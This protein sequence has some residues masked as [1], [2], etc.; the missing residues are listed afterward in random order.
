MAERGPSD[1]GTPAVVDA[2]KVQQRPDPDAFIRKRKYKKPTFSDRADKPCTVAQAGEDTGPP[3]CH[4][5]FVANLMTVNLMVKRGRKR[6]APNPK[7]VTSR[8]RKRCPPFHALWERFG[9]SRMTVEHEDW[10]DVRKYSS[11][12]FSPITISENPR[13]DFL[14]PAKIVR[15]GSEHAERMLKCSACGNVF[16]GT[17][18][19]M[20]VDGNLVMERA[21][22]E[23]MKGM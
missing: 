1:R 8:S 12:R 4:K 10:D 15:F 3:S 16:R 23:K 6:L 22:V 2:K 11:V 20:N 5:D 13:P 14:P 18:R 21:C 7:H 17:D 9:L 19:Y